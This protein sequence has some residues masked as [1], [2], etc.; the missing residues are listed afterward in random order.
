MLKM[1]KIFKAFDCNPPLDIC[2]LYLGISKVFDRVWH[3]DRVFWSD[4]DRVEQSAKLSMVIPR[5]IENISRRGA[6]FYRF[7]GVT[8]RQKSYD[9]T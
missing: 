6:S 4:H 5:G 7:W 1:T 3:D 8:Y 2:S 9:V